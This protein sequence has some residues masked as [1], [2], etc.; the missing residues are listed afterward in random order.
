MAAVRMYEEGF[1]EREDIDAAMKLGCG[2]PMGPLALCDMIGL[3]VQQSVC[4]SLFEEFK[5]SEHAPPAV[6]KR[7]VVVGYTGR[8]AGRGFYEYETSSG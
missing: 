7:M 3:D 5:R 1:A 6:L 8:K 2:H 4:A